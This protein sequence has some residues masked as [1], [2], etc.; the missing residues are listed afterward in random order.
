M[1]SSSTRGVVMFFDEWRQQVE[2]LCVSHLACAW[3]DLCGEVA[4][5]E[6]AFEAG[7]EPLAFVHWWAE[8]YDLQWFNG[9]RFDFVN[10]GAGY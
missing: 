10:F 1:L 8:K 4:P 7:E 3:D 6:S 5:L 9:G 2:A